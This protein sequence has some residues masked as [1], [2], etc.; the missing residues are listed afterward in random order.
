MYG[1]EYQCDFKSNITI[2]HYDDVCPSIRSRIHLDEFGIDN[3]YVVDC[4]VIN[5]KWGTPRVSYYANL[6]DFTGHPKWDSKECFV[7]CLED[8][9]KR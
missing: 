5:Y 7:V 9:Y 8:Q 3:G 1:I 2:I 6:S 4:V